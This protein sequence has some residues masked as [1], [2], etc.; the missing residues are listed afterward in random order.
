MKE[1][2]VKLG[3]VL[4]AFLLGIN[5]ALATLSSFISIAGT[6][7]VAEAPKWVQTTQTDFDAGVKTNVVTTNVYGG[8]VELAKVKS[9]DQSQTS[10]NKDS[11][12]IEKTKREA[13]TFQAGLSGKLTDI[14]IRAKRTGSKTK[15]LIVELRDATADDKPG[16]TILASAER[17]D[18]ETETEYNF[19]FVSP[20]TISSGTK[21]SI[22]IRQKDDGP[23]DYTVSYKDSN[24][25]V[26]GRR[27][28]SN[29]GGSTWTE[30]THDLYFKTFV[31]AYSPSGNLVSS[32]FNSTFSPA[33][34]RLIRWNADIPTGT[35]LTIQTR[36]GNTSTPDGTWSSFTNQTNNT[37]VTSPNSKYIQYKAILTT[38]D[39]SKTPVLYD[40]TIWY[41]QT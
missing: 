31:E 9:L 4:L 8:E 12:K 29:N 2:F 39:V 7:T 10:Q 1:K 15:P 24:V 37:D 30:T 34:W 40:I 21:Y 38:A 20:P 23:D 41:K 27:L 14:T 35:S 36:T 6:A 17:S 11:P 3:I 13:Q 28:T 33:D 22:V 16:T 25:Y 32:V 5:I 26:N 19:T 18:I